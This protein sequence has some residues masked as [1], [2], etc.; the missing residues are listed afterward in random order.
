M[1]AG[2]LWRHLHN[3]HWWPLTLAKVKCLASIAIIKSVLWFYPIKKQNNAFLT[4]AKTK[5]QIGQKLPK[6]QP[7]GHKIKLIG[8]LY[9][10]KG[11]APPPLRHTPTWHCMPR[12]LVPAV[13]TIIFLFI[14]SLYKNPGVFPNFRKWIMAW[15]CK[16]MF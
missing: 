2:S 1:Q 7:Q 6:M 14:S 4:R 8:A 9:H 11:A 5:S 15:A 10:P 12:F 16:L 13:A 3:I